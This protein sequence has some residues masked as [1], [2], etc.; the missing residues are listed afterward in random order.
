MTAPR[1]VLTRADWKAEPVHE[2]CPTCDVTGAAVYVAEAHPT[3]CSWMMG[4][5]HRCN[6]HDELLLPSEDTCPLPD[7]PDT[8]KDPHNRITGRIT[9]HA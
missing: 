8:W 4:N 9:E 7:V 3:F 1:R 6:E 5:L 2:K